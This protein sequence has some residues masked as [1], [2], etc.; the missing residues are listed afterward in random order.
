MEYLVFA[1]GSLLPGER[2]HDLL[3]GAEHVGPARTMPR[4]HLVELTQ[5]PALVPGGRLEVVGELYRVSRS[6]LLA[7]DVRKEVPRLFAREQIELSDGQLVHAYTLRPDQ[8]PG[9]RRLRHGDWRRR[10]EAPRPAV[11]SPLVRWAKSRR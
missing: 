10:F 7:I 2:D 11:E 6:M 3:H 4:F 8:V 5:F 9:R 1:Y